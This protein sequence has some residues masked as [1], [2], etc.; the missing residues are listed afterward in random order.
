MMRHQ[1]FQSQSQMSLRTPPQPH[2]PPHQGGYQ[3]SPSRN[4]SYGGAAGH[5]T[6]SHSRRQST[7]PPT[8]DD[9]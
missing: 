2:I 4:S 1:Q 6:P 3:Q 7:V 5:P 9:K 8:E